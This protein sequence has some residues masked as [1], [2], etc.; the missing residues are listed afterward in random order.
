MENKEN[1]L[2]TELKLI[3]ANFKSNKGRLPWPVSRGT[4]ISNF[5]KVSHPIL[6]GIIIINNGI[7]IA[8]N[9][10]NVRSV[11]DGEISKII[12]L[13]T[14]LKVVIIR[15]GEY[16]TVYSNLYNV[17]IQKGQKIKTKDYIGTLYN[18]KNK[19]KQ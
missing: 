11:F 9:N 19:K 2:A 16:L 4:I 6:S 18:D 13:P 14:G 1:N 17:S 10:N 15:H 8:T 5:G 3:S 12:I 7:E